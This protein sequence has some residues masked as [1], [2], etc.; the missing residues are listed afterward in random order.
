VE[1]VEGMIFGELAKVVGD[2]LW[3]ND[4]IGIMPEVWLGCSDSVVAEK[5]KD[6]MENI[7]GGEE[8]IAW[9]G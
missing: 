9:C 7:A 1:L 8:P 3:R 5:M 6:R 2:W 4:R